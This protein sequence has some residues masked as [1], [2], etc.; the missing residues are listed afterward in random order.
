MGNL[1]IVSG[2]IFTCKETPYLVKNGVLS[3]S[4]YFPPGLY[5]MEHSTA[6]T[7][8]VALLSPLSAE[9]QYRIYHQIFSWTISPLLSKKGPVP[10]GDIPTGEQ[11]TP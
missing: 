4:P 10:G 11:G 9:I 2:G 5:R 3:A 7:M 1:S 8:F 6:F